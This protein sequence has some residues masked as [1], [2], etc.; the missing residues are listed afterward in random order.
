MMVCAFLCCIEYSICVLACSRHEDL[1]ALINANIVIIT[2]VC[3]YTSPFNVMILCSHGMSLLL[4]ASR[5]CECMCDST[6]LLT[7]MC[8][9]HASYAR[10]CLLCQAQPNPDNGAQR[11]LQRKTS[12]P[13]L[14]N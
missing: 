13:A 1:D 6:S 10:C 12:D 11:F 8:H 4:L 3:A 9:V 5:Q 14:T 2:P 7:V